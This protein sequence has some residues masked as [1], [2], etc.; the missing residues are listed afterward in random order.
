[1]ANPSTITKEE[2]ERQLAKWSALVHDSIQLGYGDT[3]EEYVDDLRCRTLLE[4]NRDAETVKAIW[5]QV[6]RVD[7]VAKENFTKTKAS[8]HA[9][10]SETDFWFWMYPPNSPDIE[11]CLPAACLAR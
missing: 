1:M 8:I 6:A 2:A 4:Q 5:S 7:Q 10:R 11:A 3:Y 9:D